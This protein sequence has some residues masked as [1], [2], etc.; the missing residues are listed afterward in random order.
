MMKDKVTVVVVVAV[1][2]VVMQFINEKHL[3][4]EKKIL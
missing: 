1:V 4:R 2:M 3:P